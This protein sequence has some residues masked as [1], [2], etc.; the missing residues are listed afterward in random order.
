MGD[1]EKSNK[2]EICDFKEACN[3]CGLEGYYQCIDVYDGDTITILM[4]LKMCVFDCSNKPLTDDKIK[5]YQVKIR[6]YGIDTYELRPR[7]NIENR[8]EHKRKG[9]EARDLLRE[10]IL[11]KIVFVKFSDN[12]DKYS[13]VIAEIFYD[14]KNISKILIENNLGKEYYGGTKTLK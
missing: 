6:V 7:K 11:N 3:F 5:Y 14:G 2:P 13:R 4:P 12:L 8:E 9:Y 1:N 10:M